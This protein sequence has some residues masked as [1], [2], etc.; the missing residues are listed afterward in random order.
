MVRLVKEKWCPLD[1]SHTPNDET[2]ASIQASEQG[3]RLERYDSM[4][5]LF[6]ELGLQKSHDSRI[7]T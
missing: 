6:E 1:L 5:K 4:E 7:K 3:I 2:I